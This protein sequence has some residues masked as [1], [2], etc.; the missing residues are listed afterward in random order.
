VPVNGITDR[1]APLRQGQ[2]YRTAQ[3][4]PAPVGASLLAPT[5]AGETLER[6][7]LKSRAV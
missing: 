7:G 4:Y 6:F 1:E 5:G 2:R 3:A